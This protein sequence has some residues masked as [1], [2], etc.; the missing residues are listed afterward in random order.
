MTFATGEILPTP[1]GP[2]PFAVV[3]AHG[4]KV[5][6]TVPVDSVAEGEAWI[7]EVLPKLQQFARDEGHL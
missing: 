7:L 1:D 4:D 2:K 5:L 6:T 3:F